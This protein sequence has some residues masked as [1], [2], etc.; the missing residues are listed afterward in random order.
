MDLTFLLRGFVAGFLATFAML[1]AEVPVFRR[2]GRR[3]V[4]EWHEIQASLSRARRQSGIDAK[5]VFPLHFLAG[6]VGGL[7]FVVA[8]SLVSL[9]VSLVVPGLALGV[10]MWLVTLV[11][12]ERITRVHPWRN[13]MGYAP[14][15]ASLAGHLLYGAALGLLLSWP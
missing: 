8:L 12:H 15:A 10:L 4:F 6:G 14:V 2:F 11:I 7:L 9:D 1:L 3:G 13:D 5:F